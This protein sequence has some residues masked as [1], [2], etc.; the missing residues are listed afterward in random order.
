M[1]VEPSD[2][3]TRERSRVAFVTCAALPGL[4][5]DDHLAVVALAAR[6]ITVEPAVWDDPAVDWAG[7]DL[8]VLRSPWDYP[9]RHDEF[10]SWAAKV[11]HLANPADVVAWNTDKRY[12]R[13][14]AAAGIPVVA[15]EWVPPGEAWEPP[16]VGE[17]VVK[18]TV[19]AGSRDT[20][21]YN[22]TDPAQRALAVGHVE[23]L[24]GSGR[25]AMIQ[26]YLVAVDTA[27][28]TAVLCTPGPD[29][30][31]GYSHGIR[32]GPM[33]DGPDPGEAGLYRAEDI[34]VRTPSAAERELAERVLAVV[35]GGPDRLLYAR[36]DVIPGPDGEPVL[37]E[38]EL[39]EPSL[40]LTYAD[41]AAER[42]ADAILARL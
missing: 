14:L 16:R 28:E 39:T 21:R 12:L 19:S 11:P 30:R 33:L 1:T 8:A 17:Y 13:D 6:G 3:A 41:G 35:P 32:K 7:Y 10:V 26:P 40:F 29:G 18:P 27:G 31:L 38:L 15:T 4:D 20:G 9:G 42:L 36:V 34:T 5:P 23:R 2:S 22:L 25:T 37:I 24:T